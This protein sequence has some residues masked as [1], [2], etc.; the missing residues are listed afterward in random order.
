MVKENESGNCLGLRPFPQKHCSTVNERHLLIPYVV[1]SFYEKILTCFNVFLID[2]CND[3]VDGNEL[4]KKSLER[5][6]KLL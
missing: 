3:V 1:A 5:E 6:K 4:A 2:F